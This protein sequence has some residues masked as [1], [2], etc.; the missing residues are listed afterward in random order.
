MDKIQ[1][2]RGR[3]AKHRSIIAEHEAAALVIEREIVEA[4]KEQLSL[5]ARSA[6]NTLSGGMEEIFEILRGLRAKPESPNDL[7]KPSNK[8]EG[9]NVEI[10]D[11]IE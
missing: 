1:R 11:G 10:N 4:E 6:A 9:E 2:L 8:K 3:L 7:Q 5:L